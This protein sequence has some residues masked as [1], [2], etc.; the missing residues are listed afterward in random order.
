[1]GAKHGTVAERF[2][3]KVAMGTADACWLWTASRSGSGYGCLR[4]NRV[5]RTSHTLAWELT[6]GP[7]PDGLWVLHKCDVRLCCNPTHLF[8][9]TASDNARDMVAKGRNSVNGKH[10]EEHHACKLT[11]DIVASIRAA[12]ASGVS[13]SEMARRVGVTAAQ[14]NHIVHNRQ[15]REVA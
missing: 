6:N 14:V 7:I 15:W 4:V 12:V 3:P 11:K 2:W 5:T 10:G 8:L 13:Q 9:G 1:M